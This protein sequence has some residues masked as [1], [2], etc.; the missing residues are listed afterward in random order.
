MFI[1]LEYLSWRSSQEEAQLIIVGHKER[2]VFKSIKL[3][4]VV[5]TLNMYIYI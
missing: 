5:N 4:Y 3:G 1:A 2:L